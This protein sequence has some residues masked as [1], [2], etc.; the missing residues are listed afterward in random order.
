MRFTGLLGGAV[1]CCCVAAL[2]NPIK[3]W[4]ICHSVD[5]CLNLVLCN[6]FFCCFLDCLP[7]LVALAPTP[8]PLMP[9]KR[10]PWKKSHIK[11]EFNNEYLKVSCC[12]A[13]FHDALEDARKPRILYFSCGLSLSLSLI[14]L[15]LH[16][17][18][19]ADAIPSISTAVQQ[20]F[21]SESP[22]A[23]SFSRLP[24]HQDRGM[25]SADE[26][27]DEKWVRHP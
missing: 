16:K 6:M 21:D 24:S 15:K 23:S 13:S 26:S 8:P 12:H 17:E 5:A 25:N 7:A 9:L 27:V 2:R 11:P 3:W 18:V 4:H 1:R 22:A 14:S 20:Y 10:G 19:C